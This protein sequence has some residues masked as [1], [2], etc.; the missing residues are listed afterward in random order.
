MIFV[1]LK[2]DP[3]DILGIAQ[4]ARSPTDLNTGPWFYLDAR[5]DPPFIEVRSFKMAGPKLRT[6]LSILPRTS[7][8]I[9][10]ARL[11]FFL[12]II[13]YLSNQKEILTNRDFSQRNKYSD[14][15]IM[16]NCSVLSLNHL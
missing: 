6:F 10:S 5:K 2:P 4:I 3:V 14:V 13:S 1:D 7:G 11:L 8:T 16:S 9:P 15:I 12:V